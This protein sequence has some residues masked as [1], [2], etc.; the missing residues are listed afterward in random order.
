[1]LKLQR[2]LYYVLNL[3]KSFLLSSLH[4]CASWFLSGNETGSKCQ[5]KFV[6]AR[7]KGG[8][9]LVNSMNDEHCTMHSCN[10]ASSFNTFHAS[11]IWTDRAT[12][13]PIPNTI[14][15]SDGRVHRAFCRTAPRGREGRVVQM[16]S[17]VRYWR[18][19]LGQTATQV[20]GVDKL[21]AGWWKRNEVIGK[22]SNKNV[23]DKLYFKR[24]VISLCISLQWP[25]RQLST[26]VM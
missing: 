15:C 25:F 23:N 21:T 6:T 19:R 17:A 10:C 1:M 2:F 24:M 22:I 3:Q 26:W 18:W 11:H 16:F 14:S 8:I 5:P 20:H 12:S 4:L 7:M 13:Y 9:Q